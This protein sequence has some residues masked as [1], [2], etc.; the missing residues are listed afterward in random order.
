VPSTPSTPSQPPCSANK[1]EA[2]VR[3][4]G[5]AICGDL[6]SFGASAALLIARRQ[7]NAEP[8]LMAQRT[9]RVETSRRSLSNPW[10]PHGSRSPSPDTTHR[11][12]LL[13]PQPSP[14]QDPQRALRA[15]KRHVSTPSTTDSST[16]DIVETDALSI[17]GSASWM[18]TW[19]REDNARTSLNTAWSASPLTRPGP[20]DRPEPRPSLTTSLHNA[21][22]WTGATRGTDNRLT[23]A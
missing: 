8:S 3:S 12:R 2:F 23:A 13:H 9:A 7:R 17:R 16:T 1:S 20:A 22:R 19:A 4:A 10:D 5:R 15:L 14:P 6:A 18:I 11:P 21:R